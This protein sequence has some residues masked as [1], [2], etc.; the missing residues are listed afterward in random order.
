M[1]DA[2]VSFER[3]ARDPAFL[4]ALAAL[5]LSIVAL[6]T[7]AHGVLGGAGPVG[8]GVTAALVV[9]VGALLT[10][11]AV[12]RSRLAARRRAH[13]REAFF[14]ESLARLQG[15]EGFARTLGTVL[16]DGRGFFRAG[17]VAVPLR[18]RASG[19]AWLWAVPAG[20]APGTPAQAVELGAAAAEDWLFETDVEA[21]DAERVGPEWRIRAIDE[22]GRPS[23]GESRIPR[24][25]VEKLARRLGARRLTMVA[26]GRGQD[27]GGRLVLVDARPEGPGE[28]S[29]RFAQ[30][31]VREL[32]GVVQ[33]RFLLGRLRSRIGAMER[34]RVARELHDGTIQSLVGVEMEVDVL[35]RRADQAGL[36]LAGDLARVQGL[37]RSEVL[38]LRDTMQ[39][40]KPIEITPDE[41]VGFLDAAVARFGRD[42]GIR[43]IFDC[44]VEDVDLPARCLPRDRPHRPGG[45]PER[46]QAQR[47]AERA[48]P[49]RARALGLAARGGRRRTGLPLRGHPEP[50]R[51]RRG[52]Q[53][54]LRHQGTGARPRGRPDARHVSRGRG[55]AR[56][57][58]AA[59]GPMTAPSEI[60]RVVI[61]DDHPI[62]REG[63]RRLL[64]DDG[65]FEV[66]GQA[67]DG[68]DAVR[69]AREV[70]PDVLLLDLAM[71][72]AS[73]LD[74]LRELAASGAGPKVLLLTVAIDD[75]QVV[76]ALELGARGVVLKEAATELLFK[77]I[78]SVMAG[79]YWVGRDTVTDIVR[80]LRERAAALARRRP[81]PAERLTARERGIVAMVAAGASNREVAQKLSLAEDTVKHHISNIFDK[82]GVS[83]RAEM[84][85][86]AASHGLAT[87]P[88]PDETD[89]VR[90]RARAGHL[91]AGTPPG[92]VTSK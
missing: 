26:L 64:E 24:E 46:A 31:L 69:L 78:R 33:S 81:S 74:A 58:S 89:R 7:A 92:V 83:N 21:W 84:A 8:P 16:H 86:Y 35:R 4:A 61:A 36:P 11:G 65:G 43:A 15:P 23:A 66:V 56:D 88:S 3:R 39:R 12:L 18:E 68:L 54:P 52:A 5:T 82:L 47:R 44:A 6:V 10:A 41:L 2:P 1:R 40:L 63:L 55:T 90:E 85:A 17:G 25:P 28:E 79:Q 13:E 87:P 37:L 48:R 91:A 57:P 19:R 9:A 72:R 29:L 59:G 67:S 34:A 75:A 27:W 20:A 38:E 49:L 50:R 80:H 32:G 14:A 70:Q 30:R 62:L 71:P 42:T 77:A 45:P 60:I 76:E 53:G 73:G 22:A 51:A